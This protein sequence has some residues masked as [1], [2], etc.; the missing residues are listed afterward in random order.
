MSHAPPMNPPSHE[1]TD[2]SARPLEELIE[3]IELVH[4]AYLRR[5]LP[6]LRSLLA[7]IGQRRRERIEWTDLHD[8]LEAL[9]A[10]LTMHMRK[11]EMVLFPWIIDL[12]RRQAGGHAA[13]GSVGQPIAV[14]EHE[15]RDAVEALDR[16]RQLSGEFRN[17]EFEPLELELLQGLA[18]LD[19]DLRRHIEE[20][21]D[22]LFPRAKQLEQV[23]SEG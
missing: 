10:E 1:T 9:T 18:A 11:E 17:T 7:S 12:E 3:H 13:C 8:V 14:M 21:N 5:E 22:I 2:W 20:E 19:A 15:H 6:R 23:S 16:M 4:H